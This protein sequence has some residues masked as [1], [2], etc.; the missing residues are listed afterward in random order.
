M[1]GGDSMFGFGRSLLWG[2]RGVGGFFGGLLLG[3]DRMTTSSSSSSLMLALWRIF[4]FSFSPLLTDPAFFCLISASCCGDSS[5]AM[6]KSFLGLVSV[7]VDVDGVSEEEEAVGSNLIV[8]CPSLTILCPDDFLFLS[9][10]A[11]P[12]DDF[13]GPDIACDCSAGVSCFFSSANLACSANPVK[14]LTTSGQDEM[15][16]W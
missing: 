6:L 15:W 1:P 4:G 3:G 11:D 5:P 2:D 8:F 10:T 7:D 12:A 16:D 9:S 13:D 14:E